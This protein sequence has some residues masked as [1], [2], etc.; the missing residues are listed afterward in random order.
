MGACGTDNEIA[1]TSGINRRVRGFTLIELLVVIAIIAILAGMLLPALSRAKAKGLT[2]ACLNNTKQLMICYK[3]Y[4]DDNGGALLDNNVNGTSATANSW[5][6]GNVQQWS[7][8]YTNDVKDG[9]LFRYNS[10]TDIYRCPSSKAMVRGLGTGRFPHNRSYSISV[11]L[12]CPTAFGPMPGFKGFIRETEVRQPS[13]TAVFLEENAVSIDNGAIGINE[14]TG[15]AE[16]WNLPAS[17]HNGAI[18][19]LFDGSASLVTFK[20]DAVRYNKQFASD[21]TRV[22]RTN[23]ASNPAAGLSSSK[24]DSDWK[25][26][27]VL[28]PAQ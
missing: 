20:G 27:S 26:V 23:P 11:W 4:A 14:P 5:I 10:S 1:K 22:Q 12:G 17:R 21:D 15:P 24:T 9:I 18:A 16:F 28:A 2:A 19:G 25:K 3:L 13:S 7:V 8:N 6:K